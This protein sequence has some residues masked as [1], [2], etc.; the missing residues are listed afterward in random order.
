MVDFCGLP[1]IDIRVSFNSF[2]PASLNEK[3][4]EKLVNY[5]ISHLS[6][7]PSKHDKVEFDIVFSCYTLDLPQRIEILKEY[8]FAEAEVK[9]VMNALRDLTNNIIGYETG[10]WRKDYAKIKIL[11]KRYSEIDGSNMADI[12]KI[13]WFIEDCKRY[14][15]LPFAGLARAAFIAV[16]LLKSMVSTD[17]TSDKEYHQFMNGVSTVSSN[18]GI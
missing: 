16:Q 2:I 10:L 9:Q 7:D 18:M 6:D 5:Y 15:T 3:I 8:G 12:E 13:Y 1:Y 17:I 11:E 4:S 14:G